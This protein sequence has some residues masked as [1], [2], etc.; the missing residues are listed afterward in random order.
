MHR[1]VEDALD[2]GGGV[3]ARRDH[4]ELAYALRRGLEDGSLLALFPGVYSRSCEA[5]DLEVRARAVCLA[6][7]D[8]VVT[9]LAAGILGGWKGLPPA[10]FVDAATH[11]TRVSRPGF[12]LERRSIH[13]R[14]IRRMDGY[15]ITTRALTA[16]DLALV[17]HDR[18]LDDALRCGVA[19]F[20]L[21]YALSLQTGRRGLASIRR[22]VHQLRDR[23]W[24]ILERT[25]HQLL[26]DAHIEGWVANRAL[27]D[28]DGNL[29]GYGDLIFANLALVIELNSDTYHRSPDQVARDAQRDL[30]L[31]EAGW[32]VIRIRSAVVFGTPR[33]FVRIVRSLVRARQHRTPPG[34]HRIRVAS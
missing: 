24:S 30:R 12:R 29:I 19:P 13:P 14:L 15:R 1:F 25:A 10:S 8:A 20:D 6:Y 28:R 18:Y 32:E 16:I 27:T 4:P 2:A 21:R 9:G 23:P 17:Y 3:V 11:G 5:D 34:G 7:P 26:R 31:A 33:E 22:T